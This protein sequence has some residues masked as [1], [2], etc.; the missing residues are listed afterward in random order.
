[1]S[2]RHQPTRESPDS[3]GSSTTTSAARRPRADAQRNRERLLAAASAAFLG[4]GSDAD[5]SLEAVARSAGVGIG[6]LYRHFPTRQDLVE[7]VYR[8]EL[9]DVVGSAPGFL[10]GRSAAAALR[11]W[12]DRYAAFV[13]AKR[14]MADTLRNVWSSGSL[15]PS[16]TRVR[17]RATVELF[18]RA[19]VEDGTLRSDVAADDVVATLLGIFL[20]TASTADQDQVGRM[21]DLVLDGLRPR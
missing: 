12:T 13:A 4:A 20:A 10:S 21:L 9:D 19:G 7:A 17:V 11:A 15:T 14:G 6:T 5:V 16:E 3:D 8:S 1:M 18:L 2:S